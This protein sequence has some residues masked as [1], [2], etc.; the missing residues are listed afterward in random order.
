MNIIRFKVI[1]FAIGIRRVGYAY[2]KYS[3]NETYDLKEFSDPVSLFKEITIKNN[4]VITLGQ[5]NDLDNIIMYN[6]KVKDFRGNIID[7]NVELDTIIFE[8][9]DNII[10]Q[11]KINEANGLY[12]DEL[13]GEFTFLRGLYNFYNQNYDLAEELYENSLSSG[14]YPASQYLKILKKTSNS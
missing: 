1:T 6:R 9:D 12:F 7:Q 3:D 10:N 4:K 13:K 8:L 11:F 5:V 2:F 14:F